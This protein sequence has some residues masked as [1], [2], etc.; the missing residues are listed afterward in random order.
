M[1]SVDISTTIIAPSVDCGKSAL[2][3][4]DCNQCGEEYEDI[5][6]IEAGVC[7]KCEIL[8]NCEQYDS[9][10]EQKNDYPLLPLKTKDRIKNTKYL[11]KEIVR[12]WDGKT[13]GNVCEDSMCFKRPTFSN[14]DDE[15]ARFCTDHKEIG[16]IDIKNKTCIY[17]GCRTRPTFNSP[18][19]SSAIYCLLHKQAGM[20]DVISITCIY[21][22]CRTRPTFNSPG[23]SSAIYCLLHKQAGMIDVISITCIYK[24][25]RTLPTFNN[26]GE[27]R[28]I[29]CVLHKEAGMIDVKH[30]TCI[31]LNCITRAC[32]GTPGQKPTYCTKHGKKIQGMIK[33]PSKLCM[34]DNCNEKAIFGI[35]EPLHCE[36]H[37]EK[38]EENMCLQECKT[39]KNIEICNK[40]GICFEFCI[41]SDLFKRGKHLK[42]IQIQKLLETE[43][44]QEM[45]S[46]DKIIDS[47]CNK[48]RPDIVYETPTHFVIIEIDEH[49]HSSY[50]KQCEINRM[51]EIT[52]AVGMPVFFIRYNPDEWKDS[53]NKKSNITNVKREEMLIQW[54]KHT[55]KTPP[56]DQT[57]FLRVVYLFYDRFSE[58]DTN[59]ETIDVYDK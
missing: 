10:D 14:E 33:N 48:K 31:Q 19:E 13:L 32:Y 40:D 4:N 24:G 29:Y 23:E 18:G 53:S 9:K 20:I 59:I 17:K 43:I 21:K 44:K 34:V 54:I 8:A 12:K 57:E 2:I 42:E 7:E 50:E 39:C 27:S 36:T 52:F 38:D 1:N 25:C 55:L 41:N 58:N 56:K 46:C 30:I 22:G 47:S 6:F 49:Q 37:K 26:L 15:N 51:K 16:M 5:D 3:I 45:F 11:Y 28:A 35:K